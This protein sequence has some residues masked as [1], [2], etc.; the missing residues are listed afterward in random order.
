MNPRAILLPRMF[1][2]QKQS[3][4]SI[5]SIKT[6][7]VGRR[8]N[9]TVQPFWLY[10]AYTIIACTSF[11]MF[12]YL[13]GVNTQASTGYEIQ[14]IQEKI[15]SLT[16]QNKQLNLKISKQASIAQIQNDYLSQGYA[17]VKQSNFLRVNNY[18]QK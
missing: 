12:S 7:A 1:G 9:N 15:I 14:K 10:A 2:A 6:Q 5:Q 3:S 13:L 16:D 18:T 8:K 11:L 4:R 17:V